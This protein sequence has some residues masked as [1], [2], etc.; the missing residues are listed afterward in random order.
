MFFRRNNK[1]SKKKLNSDNVTENL[2][3][4][5]I[6][7]LF[8]NMADFNKVNLNT[9]GGNNYILYFLKSLINVD[10]L[11]ITVILPLLHGNTKTM[12]L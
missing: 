4:E 1:S 8:S 5:K 11:N 3:A 6:E 12:F 7:S 2:T 9:P 10:Q